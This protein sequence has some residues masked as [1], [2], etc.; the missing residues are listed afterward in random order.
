MGA[1]TG[2]AWRQGGKET[3]HHCDSPQAGSAAAS[4]VGQWRSLRTAAQYEAGDVGSSL[5]I[6]GTAKAQSRV[7][8]TASNAWPTSILNH[9]RQVA[10]Q[11]AAPAE[12]RTPNLHRANIAHQES[13]WKGGD[14]G[15]SATEE[16]LA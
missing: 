16:N 8:V 6:R 9:G 5:V 14:S 11:V 7:P 3:S 1:E 2:R 15:D 4:A 10:K 12:M 13:G